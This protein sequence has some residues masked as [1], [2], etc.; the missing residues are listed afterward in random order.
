MKKRVL[1]I[2]L[3]YI[4]KNIDSTRPKIRSFLAFP[5]G[6]LS[7]AT[8]NKDLAEF[9]IEDL[10]TWANVTEYTFETILKEFNPEIVG[11]S[12]MFDNSYGWLEPLSETVKKFNRDIL[13]VLGGAAASYSYQEILDE[14]NY[15]DAVCFGEG[16]IPFRAL[17]QS[18][19][20]LECLRERVGW[21]TRKLLQRGDAPK[22]SY[23]PN[24][25]TLIDID[26]S[27][28]DPSLY[29]MQQAFSPY[30]GHGKHKQFFLMTSRGCPFSC[31]FCSNAKIH[32]KKMRFASV[33]RI[34][35]HVRHLVDDYNMDV[36]TIYDDQLLIDTGRAKDLFKKLAPFGL[37]VEMPNGLSVR[38]IDR[39]MA[40]YMAESGVDTAYLA[41]ES[42]SEYVLKKLIK[43]P[44]ELSMVKPAVEALR[45]V[46]IFCHGFF[47]VG[48]P[49]E[50]DEMRAETVRFIKE[51]DLDWAGLNPA[52]PVRGSELYENCIRNGWIKKQRIGEIEDKRY[53][54]EVPGVD[55]NHIID[56]IH[57][58]NMEINFHNNRAMRMGDYTTAIRCFEEV[59]R[60]Y[61]GHKEAK[62]Y[63]E[64]CRERMES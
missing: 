62:R 63:L 8:Y 56:Q 22:T 4:V 37:R 11:F 27:F 54:I 21:V 46:G 15:L 39:W 33:D 3:P 57:N 23:I 32:G 50:T 14:Q 19:L 30:A 59:I 16:E 51:V 2:N 24:L 41:I 26:Y 47:V 43:K 52:T 36:L 35:A 55:P 61:E 18:D 44:L 25:D 58:M 1:L 48:I 40:E 38:Y 5:Y 29:D 42:G 64:I 7:V 60:R 31:T 13:V 17:L 34:I 45:E 6:L 10:D 20:L 28:V 12:M 9:R 49:G 53:I